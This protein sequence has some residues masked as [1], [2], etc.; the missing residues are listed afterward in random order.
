MARAGFGTRAKDVMCAGGSGLTH[1]FNSMNWAGVEILPG[2][3]CKSCALKK[4]QARRSTQIHGEENEG[5]MEAMAARMKAQPWN[6]VAEE[7]AEHP[8]GR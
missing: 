3:R 8:L 1:R 2:E 5:L 4:V 7:L 6:S